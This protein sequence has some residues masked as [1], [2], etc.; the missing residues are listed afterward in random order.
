MSNENDGL[1]TEAKAAI[2][3]VIFVL[4]L[5]LA[6]FTFIPHM[7]F[8]YESVKSTDVADMTDK[9]ML[10]GSAYMSV[11]EFE[12]AQ[13]DSVVTSLAAEYEQNGTHI[14]EIQI[15]SEL[16]EDDICWLIAI[17]SANK[18]QDL[19]VMTVPE[20]RSLSISSLESSW[21]LFGGE[22][23]IL[24]VDF[25]AM[26]PQELMDKLGMSA[27]KKNWAEAFFKTLSE[28]KALE[29]YG[30]YYDVPLP[31][32]SGDGPYGGGIEHGGGYG[33]DIDTSGFTSINTKNGHDLAAYA[34]QAYENNWGYV[35]GT[36][37]C[38]LTE[39]LFQYKLR[40]YPQGVGNYAQFIRDNWLGRRTTDC[41]GLIKGYG[42]LDPLTLAINYGT[43]GM[44]DLS[45]DQMGQ[46]AKNAGK[47]SY[48]PIS[49]IPEI[50]GLALC[51]SGHIGVYIGNGYAI[52]AMGTKYGVV[53]TQVAGRGWSF[54]CKIPYISYP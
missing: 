32:Y 13:M 15:V 19:N 25:S 50:P 17:N 27:S 33:N 47:S 12:K 54:W 24:R 26:D 51:K 1:S 21:S 40:Q 39:S 14:D 53:K 20:V 30:S 5:P 28:S 18:E 10:I 36:Y 48:G 42:W 16:D 4:L 44:P 45:A 8:G 6:I 38:V 34:I 22:K 35:W 3:I 49:T 52:E 29:K 9:A 31:D 7:F 37:G 11:E 41:V 2:A 46:A 23:N 43:N